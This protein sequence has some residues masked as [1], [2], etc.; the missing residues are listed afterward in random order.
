MFDD[1][2]VEVLKQDGFLHR[3]SIFHN[4]SEHWLIEELKYFISQ[5]S[6]TGDPISWK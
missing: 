4:P 5:F 6:R 3:N 2:L 1:N